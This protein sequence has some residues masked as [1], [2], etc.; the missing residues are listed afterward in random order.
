MK[1]VYTFLIFLITTHPAW[2]LLEFED[3]TSPE[4]V[5]SARALAMGNAYMSK[6]DDGWAPFYNPAGLG[7]V[8]G[9]RFHLSNLHLETNNGY[10][11]ITGGSGNFFSSAGNYTRAFD[12]VGLR[13]L[14]AESP[15]EI[16]HARFQLF[17]NI[18]FR[19]I[20]FGY[21]YIQ[22]NRARLRSTADDFEIAERTDY[23]PVLAVNLSFFGG[24]LKVG[25]TA[26]LLTR[27]QLQ[28]D[29]AADDPIE[30]DADTDYTKGTMTHI[31]AGSR[32]TLP[33]WAL[34]TLSAVV[35]NSGETE[36]SS[37]ELSGAPP[38]I[39]Q[40]VDYSF[41]LTP[42]LGR[43]SRIHMEVTMR[44]A[45]NEYENVPSQRKLQAGIEIDY[46]RKVFVRF[47]YGDGWGSGGIGVRNNKFAFDL[48]TYA[49]EASEDGVREE[50]DRRYAISISG[51][52]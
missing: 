22:Q 1:Y 47:G 21:M 15:G 50:E 31:T 9:L 51:G 11:D 29:F 37:P 35:R 14:H 12:P 42:N 40:T 3:A 20:S 38:V 17:P 2:G 43:T 33:F 13:D 45:T 28:K 18:T 32:I 7:T 34:P 4:F 46:V 27:K 25:G 44:D 19:G 39:P 26:T 52:F 48:S 36:W 16:S 8:R 41:S 24:V 5:T 10:F 30:I 23:G 49:I 6:V